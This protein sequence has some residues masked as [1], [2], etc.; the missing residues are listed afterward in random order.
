MLSW[1]AGAQPTLRYN[2]VVSCKI[3]GSLV[4]EPPKKRHEYRP[5]GLRTHGSLLTRRS[6]VQGPACTI[7]FFATMTSS[8]S[9]Q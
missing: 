1:S 7:A 6:S 9:V 4:R 8:I 5:E 3:A 2:D